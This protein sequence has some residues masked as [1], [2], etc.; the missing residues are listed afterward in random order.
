MAKAI[1]KIGGL[2]QDPVYNNLTVSK[3][4]NYVM[5]RGQKLTAQNIVYSAFKIIEEKEKKDP[6]KV[7]ELAIQNTS[8]SV[9]VKSKRV[10][11][12]TYQVPFPVKKNRALFLS[13]NWIINAAKAKKGQAM[14]EKLAKELIDAANNTGGAVQ[15]KEEIHKI[16][17][18]NRAFAHF[19]NY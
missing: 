15:K 17:N 8:P 10:G 13:L 9:E 19:A 3:F 7:F 5:E 16:A 1:K 2:K 11:G 18:A 14:K 12:A 6:I 4:I